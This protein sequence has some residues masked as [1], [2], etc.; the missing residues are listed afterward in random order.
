MLV[1]PRY[2]I[3][4]VAIVNGSLLLIWLS[5]SLLLVYRDACDFCMLILYPESLLKLLVSLSRF[6][7][8]MIGSSKY[9]IMLPGNGNNFTSFFLVEYH[10]FLLLL[11]LPNCS[12][13]NFQYY[14][15]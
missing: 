15:E 8:E 5:V 13:Q 9:T 12:S 2:F 6:W 7:A 1:V 3:L 14:I 11:L 10:I 4:F